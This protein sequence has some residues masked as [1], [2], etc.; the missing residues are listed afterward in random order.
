MSTGVGCRCN[1]L[2]DQCQEFEDTDKV[3]QPKRIF[4]VCNDENNSECVR[5]NGNTS[6]LPF[7][8]SRARHSPQVAGQ[9][10]GVA[11]TER[12]Q[13]RLDRKRNREEVFRSRIC[14]FQV[15]DLGAAAVGEVAGQFEVDAE[16]G[17]SHEEANDPNEKGQADRSRSVQDTRSYSKSVRA[18]YQLHQDPTH[19]LRRYQCQSS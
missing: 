19:A 7:R 18:M 11:A 15:D 6:H 10:D 4:V 12:Q 3:G 16:A 1:N 5:S 14:L 2:Q 8:G 9:D 17:G 13:H